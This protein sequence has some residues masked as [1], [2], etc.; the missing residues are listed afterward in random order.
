VLWLTVL[1]LQTV[2]WLVTVL[3]LVGLLVLGLRLPRDTAVEVQ[4]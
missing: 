2:L 3:V 1:W 4:G